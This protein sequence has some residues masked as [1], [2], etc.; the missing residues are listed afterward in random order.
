M[1]SL[2]GRSV[3]LGLGWWL[4]MAAVVVLAAWRLWH[5]MGML[6]ATA[7]P[8]PTSHPWSRLPVMV[9]TVNDICMCVMY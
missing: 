3:C 7:S 4:L 5:L 2:C 1:P 8:L 6:P 9:V